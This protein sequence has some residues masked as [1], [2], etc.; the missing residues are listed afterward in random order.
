MPLTN[1]KVGDVY[2]TRDRTKVVR[3]LATDYK[4]A[5]GFT[6]VGAATVKNALTPSEYLMLWRGDGS[7]SA[8]YEHLNDLIPLDEV[9]HTLWFKDA[10][11]GWRTW[12]MIYEARIPDVEKELASLKEALRYTAGMTVQ[13]HVTTVTLPSEPS[14]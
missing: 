4:D 5:S 13:M 6:L 10:K 2:Q 12:G 14:K 7:V 3:V 11:R 8:T 1:V 9:V